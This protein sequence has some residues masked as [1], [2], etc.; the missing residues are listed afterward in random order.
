M[1]VIALLSKVTYTSALETR[2][3][4]TPGEDLLAF[5]RSHSTNGS[6]THRWLGIAVAWQHHARICPFDHGH[7]SLGRRPAHYHPREITR[8]CLCRADCGT[9]RLQ[10]CIRYVGWLLASAAQGDS[11][12][13]AAF[14]RLCR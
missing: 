6:K 5:P 13:G 4:Y 2:Y 1:N 7:V 10:G 11:L 3:A 14:P 9:S 12:G 8:F